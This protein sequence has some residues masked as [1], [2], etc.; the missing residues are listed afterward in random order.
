MTSE[1]RNLE[2][3]GDGGGDGPDNPFQA[4]AS[5]NDQGRPDDGGAGVDDD[6][7]GPPWELPGS[8]SDRY[9]G[10]LWGVLFRPGRLFGEFRRLG[11]V[12]APVMFASIAFV[13]GG[14]V[15]GVYGLV[16]IAAMTHLDVFEEFRSLPGIDLEQQG[17]QLQVQTIV[18]AILN[19]PIMIVA[20][21]IVAGVW[22]MMLAMLRANPYP[23]EATERVV[24]YAVGSTY[25]VRLIPV[26]GIFWPL[27]TLITVIFGLM[28]VHRTT[29]GTASLAVLLP[30][31][32]CCCCCGCSY[33]VIISAMVQGG[34]IQP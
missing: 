28:K 18:L 9:F 34:G 6:G 25:V 29:G 10:T 8:L 31:G 30:V 20:C 7:D 22:H 3:I 27:W 23:F 26:I 16:A 5:R 33:A 1:Q 13:I 24:F 2:P 19:A 12:G 14:I 4:P 32:M 15:A 21:F 17:A 11:G